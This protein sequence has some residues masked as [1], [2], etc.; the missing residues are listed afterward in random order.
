M[1]Q[2]NPGRPRTFTIKSIRKLEH[3]EGTPG[4][5]ACSPEAGDGSDTPPC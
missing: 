1:L 4:S 3:A 2:V 5:G